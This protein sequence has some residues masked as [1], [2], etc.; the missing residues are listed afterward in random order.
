[1]HGRAGKGMPAKE[2]DGEGEEAGEKKD[3][4][5]F[6]YLSWEDKNKKTNRKRKSLGIPPPTAQPQQTQPPHPFAESAPS[7]GTP[8][9]AGRT[10]TLSIEEQKMLLDSMKRRRVAEGEG[11][12]LQ[13]GVRGKGFSSHTSSSQPTATSPVARQSGTNTSPSA[14]G[15]DLQWQQHLQHQQPQEQPQPSGEEDLEGG[16]SSVGGTSIPKKSLMFGITSVGSGLSYVKKRSVRSP[17]F[18]FTVFSSRDHGMESILERTI[19]LFF[20]CFA[21]TRIP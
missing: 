16:I 17:Y 14:T 11:F 7:G 20:I 15:F 4:G 2:D 5:L 19:Y 12:G 13:S 18:Y 9:P 6:S 1:M 3:E 21:I 10:G 8:T